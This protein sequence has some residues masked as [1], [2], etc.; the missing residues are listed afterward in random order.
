MKAAPTVE[1]S[2]KNI[3]S[4]FCI[5]QRLFFGKSISSKK[6]IPLVSTDFMGFFSVETMENTCKSHC[7]MKNKESNKISGGGNSL[8]KICLEKS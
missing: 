8:W 2:F 5:T 6:L 3:G 4:F 7:L 1:F